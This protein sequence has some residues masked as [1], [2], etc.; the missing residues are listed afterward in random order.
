MTKIRTNAV[1]QQATFAEITPS[2]TLKPG[3][4]N[5][6]DS[7]DG[8]KYLMQGRKIIKDQLDNEDGISYNPRFNHFTGSVNASI[9]L[10]HLMY[11]WAKA[12][13]SVFYKFR[14][15]CRHKKYEQGK[16][17][18]EEL[19]FSRCQFLE[20]GEFSAKRDKRT[21]TSLRAH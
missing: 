1:L 10:Q 13:Y 11:C 8:H 5:W 19:G 3:S 12:E 4:T 17:W 21:L 6:R 18:T 9:L 7:M 15:P 2:E 20:F 14:A 16:S